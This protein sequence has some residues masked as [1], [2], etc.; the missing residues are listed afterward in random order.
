[1][2]SVFTPILKRSTLG[3][4][5][6]PILLNLCLL[7]GEFTAVEVYIVPRLNLY[8]TIHVE[9]NI[10]Y[11]ADNRWYSEQASP[12]R[13]AGLKIKYK[14]DIPLRLLATANGCVFTRERDI[15]TTSSKTNVA[16]KVQRKLAL[17]NINWVNPRMAP[18]IGKRVRGTK[19]ATIIYQFTR[20]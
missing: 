19:Y 15:R 12:L 4:R 10:C 13:F 8:G 9:R 18:A 5:D 6:S 14:S 11:D 7:F 3:A 2:A 17:M 1:M 16:N 20:L